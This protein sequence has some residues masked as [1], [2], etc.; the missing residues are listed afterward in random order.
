METRSWK[1]S[2]FDQSTSEFDQNASEKISKI[3]ISE[4]LVLGMVQNGKLG[5]KNLA[6]IFSDVS[7][8]SENSEFSTFP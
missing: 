5:G 4:F 1:T 6:K 2:E 8:Y 7:E 3:Y